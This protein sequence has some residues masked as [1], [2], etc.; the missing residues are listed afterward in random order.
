MN[1]AVLGAGIAGLSVA[2]HLK[3]LGHTVHLYDRGALVAGNTS[4]A[5]GILTFLLDHPEDL[6]AVQRSRQLYA[7]AEEQ[8]RG[9]FR[10][11]RTGLVR[12]ARSDPSARA[13]EV[14]E[15]Q[16]KQAGLPVHRSLPPDFPRPEGLQAALFSPED[17]YVDPSAFALALY[18]Y[19]RATQTPVHLYEPVQEIRAQ[20][21]SWQV[22]TSHRRETYD[23]LVLAL[24]VWTGVFL[25][26][27]L[28]KPLPL[29]PYR[30]QAARLVLQRRMPGLYDMDTGVY[31]IPES[32]GQYIVG[33]GT[34][35]RAYTPDA[36]PEHADETFYQE[37][38]GVLADLFPFLAEEA[39]LGRG[40]AGLLAGT[41]D[42][43]PLAG[44]YPGLEGLWIFT[45]FNG[46]GIMRAPGYA[47]LLARA[48]HEHREP[49][50]FLSLRRF[51]S[52]DLSFQ[53]RPGFPP[54]ASS[55]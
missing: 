44:P 36:F 22:R 20:G 46:Y 23:L 26:K 9:I 16:V 12:L 47:E 31:W 34:D 53:P 3:T 15:R 11:R 49:P 48:I 41:P 10:Y 2:Y 50:D 27:T 52:L 29:Q 38:A 33:D 1:I 28:G 21:S 18:T 7:V 40:W 37:I 25:R 39:R 14:V 30:S 4:R 32:T 45:G 55:V 35:L 6:E 51:P 13:L 43:F 24:G 42:R 19:F 54:L 17:G 8:S 5:A